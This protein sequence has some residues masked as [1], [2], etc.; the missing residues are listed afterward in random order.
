MA[1]LLVGNRLASGR[2]VLLE[3]VL[4]V[5]EETVWFWLEPSGVSLLKILPIAKTFLWHP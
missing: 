2:C 4:Q 1:A 3:H 5:C